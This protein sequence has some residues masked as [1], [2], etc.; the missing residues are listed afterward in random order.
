MLSSDIGIVFCAH[1][2]WNSSWE[3]IHQFAWMCGRER[4]TLFVDHTGLE[5]F[6]LG[7]LEQSLQDLVAKVR[8]HGNENIQHP[9][10]VN[11]KMGNLKRC[12]PWQLPASGDKHSQQL[13]A[14]M[15]T[16]KV[17]KIMEKEGMKRAVLWAAA[18]TENVVSLMKAYPWEAVIF[19]CVA[20]MPEAYPFEQKRVLA[21][22]GALMRRADIVLCLSHLLEQKM[23]R[24]KRPTVFHLPNGLDLD[25]FAR[26]SQTP[27]ELAS[28]RRPILGY[29]G[30]MQEK[31]FDITLVA[32]LAKSHPEWSIVLVGAVT[33][34]LV[35]KIDD[36]P[37]HLVGLVSH[38]D[39]PA[40]MRAF[41]VALNPVISSAVTRAS[42]PKK[43]FEYLACGLPVISTPIPDLDVFGDLVIQVNGGDRF[44]FAVHAALE[45]GRQRAAQR[46]QAVFPY[47]W[48]RLLSQVEN[49]L[50]QLI[51]QRVAP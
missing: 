28:L 32:N 22:E 24:Y 33:K 27:P 12:S 7:Q 15:F 36:A 10:S 30:N 35:V 11:E 39:V 40:Y 14:K 41:D 38:D 19:D 31:F 1:V 5:P 6:T 34:S 3:R 49:K 16:K 42:N 26:P 8:G 50:E 23:L 44:S 25:R 20:D 18:P 2:D 47:D 37:L 48:T 45:E 29:V 43:I 51:A 4:K 17:K 21:A 46:Q 13:N 9:A